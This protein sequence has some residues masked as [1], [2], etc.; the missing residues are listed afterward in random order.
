MSILSKRKKKKR[1]HIKVGSELT[2]EVLHPT[3]ESP[4]STRM[5]LYSVV[6]EPT[7]RCTGVGLS[8]SFSAPTYINLLTR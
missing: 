1:I 4:F 5:A 3:L 6:E 8:F 2:I 7:N